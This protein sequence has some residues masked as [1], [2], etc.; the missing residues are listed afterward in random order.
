[1]VTNSPDVYEANRAAHPNLLHAQWA[2]TGFWD[3]RRTPKP[4][5]F[6]FVGQVYGTRAEQIRGLHRRAGLVAYGK[7]AGIVYGR[8]NESVPMKKR[9]TRRVQ[10]FVLRTL[11]PSAFT[12]WSTISFEQVNELWN[13]SRVS[14]TPLESSAG[15]VLQIKSRVMDMGLSGTLM[16]APKGPASSG[17]TSRARSSWSTTT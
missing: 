8:P 3:G 13:Q 11:V 12:A 1:M 15:G 2:C 17:T 16:L 4:I 14:F 9:L 10:G 7:G 6:S 5:D